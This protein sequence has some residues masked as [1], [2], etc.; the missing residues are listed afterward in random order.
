[1]ESID[2]KKPTGSDAANEITNC[3]AVF[4]AATFDTADDAADTEP[5]ALS[6][7]VGGIGI[8]A[9]DEA[10][11]V[12]ASVV[13]P[14]ESGGIG[15]AAGDEASVV[16]ASVIEPAE[17]G[18]IKLSATADDAGPP[19]ESVDATPPPAALSGA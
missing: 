14:A 16:E 4:F 1:M 8:A 5:L 7:D 17:T 9:G 12:E 3:C 11:V 19:D 6:S 13:E 10:S 15:I 2:S 18:G